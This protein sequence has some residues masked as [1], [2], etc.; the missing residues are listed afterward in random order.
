MGG[1]LLADIDDGGNL[2]VHLTLPA[3]KRP[4]AKPLPASAA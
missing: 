3:A 1:R 2:R 4:E